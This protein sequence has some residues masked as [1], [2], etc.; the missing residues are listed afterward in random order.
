MCW[1]VY[2][3]GMNNSQHS[4]RR[5]PSKFLHT[6]FCYSLIFCIDLEGMDC[7]IKRVMSSREEKLDYTWVRCLWLMVRAKAA[8]RLWRYGWRHKRLNN[9]LP[10]R[11]L[12]KFLTAPYPALMKVR[13]SCLIPE[14][15]R[16]K[17]CPRYHNKNRDL[18]YFS[19]SLFL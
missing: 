16:F 2:L 5:P 13:P 6:V 1:I 3:L 11:V 9:L 4:N 19:K 10:Q 15:H 12:K 7:Q 18:G 8:K 14:G 17:C